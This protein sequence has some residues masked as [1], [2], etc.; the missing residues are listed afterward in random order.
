MELII[1]KLFKSF[2]DKH[3]LESLA[4]FF[5]GILCC[6][7]YLQN[8][9]KFF[10]RIDAVTDA[11]NDVVELLKYFD[12]LRTKYEIRRKLEK[13]KDLDSGDL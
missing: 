2:F 1:E 10:E 3:T 12:K 13:G 9:L 5:G 8:N 11:L 6:L 4:L 7:W